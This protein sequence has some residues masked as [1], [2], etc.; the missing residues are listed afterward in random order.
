MSHNDL[1]M[2]VSKE[3]FKLNK[4]FLSFRINKELFSHSSSHLEPQSEEDI[5]VTNLTSNYLAF[6]TKTTKKENYLVNPT[7]CIIPPNG[8]QVLNFT[9]HNK[10][11]AKLDIKNHK[12]KF[13]GFIIKESEKD[14]DIKNLFQKYIINGT[15]VVGNIKKCHS[16]FIEEKNEGSN[17]R[18]SNESLGKL[19]NSMSNLSEYTV[20]EDNNSNS[21]LKEKIK[22]KEE[23]NLRLSDIIENKGGRHIVDES[24]KEKLESLKMK[25]EQLKG[26]F[27]NLKRNEELLNQRIYN[28]RNKKNE[29]RG[30]EK[31]I[32][33]VPVIKE[34]TL[35]RNVLISIFALSVLIGFYLVK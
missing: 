18:T 15:L 22:E 2:D 27:D 19:G 7:Y 30:A 9:F 13:E 3:V 10:T 32:Y 5:I 33:K 16:Q 1:I 25:Y 29:I 31:F 14:E 11:G 12:F 26:E 20:A 4:E 28:E 34:K 6:R 23:E 35:P 24:N 17:L 8:T 21:L